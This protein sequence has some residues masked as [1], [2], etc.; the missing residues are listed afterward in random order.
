MV[1]LRCQWRGFGGLVFATSLSFLLALARTQRPRSGIINE[2]D[3]QKLHKKHPSFIKATFDGLEELIKLF[4][5]TQII[6]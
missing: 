2:E 5:S 4:G 3:Y 6:R 1:P